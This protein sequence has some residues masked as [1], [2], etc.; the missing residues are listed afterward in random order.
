MTVR[1]PF[2][3]GSFYDAEPDACRKHAQHLIDAAELPGDLPGLCLAGL[4]PHAGWSF[5]GRLAAL[6][7]K[8][9]LRDPLPETLILFGA[10]HTGASHS[11]KPA[12]QVYPGEAWQTPPGELAVD[13]DLAQALLEHPQ[14]GLLLAANPQAHAREHS[15]E[16]QLPLIQLLAPD[17][18][19][20]PITMPS[21]SVAIEAGQAIAAA[22]QGGPRVAFVGSTD[23]THH[24][25]HFGNPG[26]YGEDS[27]AFA[28]R[29]DQRMLD[30]I[31]SLAV[32]EILPEA[33]SHHNACGPGAI[34]ATLAAARQLGATD[35][36]VLAY[37]NSY[38]IVRQQM[39]HVRDDTTVGYAS[40][41]LA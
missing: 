3:A 12:G 31:R 17:V 25:G 22:T 19:I 34:A 40:V 21:A 29:N 33:Q 15:I 28:R 11:G 24:G 16:V 13:V 18:K 14:A 7:L 9:V 6:T 20:L 27:E 10:D 8:A 30:C 38:E 39:P 23:L 1:T 35:V 37:T 32:D 2:R 4:V 5:S 26:G 41:V 36:R